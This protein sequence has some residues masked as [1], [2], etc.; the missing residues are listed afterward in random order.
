M[1]ALERVK[2]EMSGRPPGG[3]GQALD[4]SP[5]FRRDVQ[6]GGTIQKSSTYYF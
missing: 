4:R 2:V 5:N 6:V 1:F 3:D